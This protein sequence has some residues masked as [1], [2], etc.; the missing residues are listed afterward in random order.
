MK[1]Q[2]ANWMSYYQSNI[3]ALPMCKISYL[4]LFY[5]QSYALFR[6]GYVF[7]DTLYYPC[8]ENKGADQLRSNFALAKIWF[9]H[10]AAHLV[11]QAFSSSLTH[12]EMPEFELKVF[13]EILEKKAFVC[14]FV[15]R[16][17][18]PVNRVI[19]FCLFLFI[20]FLFSFTS[21]SRLFQLI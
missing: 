10:D 15:L 1:H 16:F 4:Y 17:N 20:F 14:L 12:K 7:W 2:L 18:V 21:L 5:L 3:I 6:S 11:L 19:A 9:S 8:S 13:R